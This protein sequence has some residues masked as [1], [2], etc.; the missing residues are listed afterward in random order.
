MDLNSR[1]TVF[2]RVLDRLG[3]LSE[4]EARLVY[5]TYAN[6]AFELAVV[7]A[8]CVPMPWLP[9]M[10]EAQPKGQKAMAQSLKLIADALAGEAAILTHQEGH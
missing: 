9:F 5:R 3:D 1:N 10:L 8:E 4:G 2:N 7:R 6:E